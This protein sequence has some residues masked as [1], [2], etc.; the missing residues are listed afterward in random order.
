[1][2]DAA[3]EKLSIGAYKELLGSMQSDANQD[4]VQSLSKIL[5]NFPSATPKE[6]RD[7]ILRAHNT[8]FTNRRT[9]AYLALAG[10]LLLLA[11]AIAGAIVDGLTFAPVCALEAPDAAT[12]EKGG[13]AGCTRIVA[14][15]A[16]ASTIMG[17][18][19]GTLTTIVLSYYLSSAVRPSS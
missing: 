8:R 2:T 9:M 10:L 17:I 15:L 12:I 6:D 11:I 16:E 7:E 19:I 5:K 18:L 14:S 13:D 4:P 3:E 1:M